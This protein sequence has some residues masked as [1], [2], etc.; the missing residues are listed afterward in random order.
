MEVLVQIKEDRD[1]ILTQ[2]VKEIKEVKED[3]KLSL[4]LQTQ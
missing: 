4:P 1:T 2:E 3:F